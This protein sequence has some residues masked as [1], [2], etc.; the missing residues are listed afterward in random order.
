MIDMVNILSGQERSPYMLLH[1]PAMRPDLLSISAYQ[2][3]SGE[4]A[5]WHSIILLPKNSAI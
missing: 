3:R 1:N 2:S 4:F 5:K